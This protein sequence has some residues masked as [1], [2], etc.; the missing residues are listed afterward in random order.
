MLLRFVRFICVHSTPQNTVSFH[1]QGI[2]IKS[3]AQGK[4]DFSSI[5]EAHGIIIDACKNT[6]TPFTWLSD[7]NTLVETMMIMSWKAEGDSE[8]KCADRARAITNDVAEAVKNEQRKMLITELES[9]R[10][11]NLW[12][13]CSNAVPV[14]VAHSIWQ[15][16]MSS[17]IQ[18]QCSG[19]NL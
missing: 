8:G 4:P 12:Q 11:T 3:F 9:P 2:Y 17:I 13:V 14:V 18:K 1:G 5:W 7:S 16:L 15:I 6:G 19:D 10:Y